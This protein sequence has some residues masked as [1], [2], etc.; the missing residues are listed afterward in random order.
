MIKNI[1]DSKSIDSHHIHDINN[2]S[3]EFRVKKDERYRIIIWLNV[4]LKMCSPFGSNDFPV[5]I[6]M[7]VGE[8]NP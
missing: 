8:K 7:G 6:D 2:Y 3:I 1:L 4:L 5:G